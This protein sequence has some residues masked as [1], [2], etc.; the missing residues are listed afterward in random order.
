MLDFLS[1]PGLFGQAISKPL[2]FAS[3]IIIGVSG[4]VVLV[5]LFMRRKD[6]DNDNSPSPSSDSDSDF[7]LNKKY[8]E[9]YLETYKKLED[10]DLSYNVDNDIKFIEDLTPVGVVKMGFHADN[11]YFVYYCNKKDIPYKYLET[12]ARLYVIEMNCKN[13]Y[14]NY[15]DELKKAI[16]KVVTSK[17]NIE[18]EI[19][20]TPKKDSVFAQLKNYKIEKANTTKKWIIP[21]RMNKYKYKG[22]LRDYK[23]DNNKNT[24]RLKYGSDFEHLDY[25]TFKK[26]KLLEKKTSM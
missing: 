4:A 7:E 18:P 19:D 14:I 10:N 3:T 23:N 8:E 16:D 15:E 17:D 5:S 20:V 25:A 11:D 13:I 26:L 1:Y 6:E 2:I 22:T 21:D 9:K 12:V 24:H